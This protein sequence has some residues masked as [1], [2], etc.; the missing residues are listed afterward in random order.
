MKII[1]QIIIISGLFLTGAKLDARLF[2]IGSNPSLSKIAFP[3]DIL[4]IK[5]SSIS[6]TLGYQFLPYWGDVDNAVNKPNS[7]YAS[8][9]EEI[10]FPVELED[11]H[12]STFKKSGRV[13]MF[14]HSI[15]YNR[16]WTNR[17]S[18]MFTL[19]YKH[20]DMKSDASGTLPATDNEPDL[21]Y[22]GFDYKSLRKSWLFYFESIL[23]YKAG[24]VPLG[25]KLG[26]GYE[27]DN[28][29]VSKFKSIAHGRYMESKRLLWGWSTVGC[30]HIFG[31]R[32]LRGDA[33]FKNS[34]TAGPT[35]QLD[36]QAG[37][38]FKRAKVGARYR[39]R[40]GKK[41]NYKWFPLFDYGDEALPE[42]QY[43]ENFMGDYVKHKWS[44]ESYEH[45]GRIYVN[46]LLKKAKMGNINL[47]VF[48][49]V[50]HFESKNVISEDSDFTN[51]S[52]EGFVN[53]VGE[54]NP[55]VNIFL[56]R[57]VVIDA[58]MLCEF[59]WTGFKNMQDRWA[60]SIGARKETYS[61][62]YVHIGDEPSWESFSHATEYFFDLGFEINIQ[63]PL[64]KNKDHLLAVTLVFFN[65]NKFTFIDKRYGVNE[66]IFY[67]I[68]F[69]SNAQRKIEKEE[70][71]LNTSITLFYKYKHF[72]LSFTYIE[73][74]IYS[75]KQKE[76]IVGPM[77]CRLYT[78]EK[79]M[80]TSIF[81][82]GNISPNPTM[83]GS[84]MLMISA[85]YQF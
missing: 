26:F 32:H 16:I 20:M 84:E 9:S 22:V 36:I 33:W 78:R 14:R 64:F 15:K 31:Y 55:N 3:Q 65:N 30:N 44:N 23:S 51:S 21:E 59:S 35:Y 56:G 45:I 58:G 29:P 83:T 79:R 24:T 82:S 48:F 61:N 71:W 12:M 70:I 25:L 63:A 62:S 66:E 5:R 73:P 67:D 17:L 60:G 77:H 75:L 2:F 53:L 43:V 50:D 57:G 4:L 80:Q 47:L 27:E 18:T 11:V 6:Y 39:L 46:A 81:E 69:V 40:I 7:S 13:K 52:K 1:I 38:T 74:I 37:A 42:E 68:K 10:T 76:Y 41:D 19:T 49:A 28:K 8:I 72:F 54:L 85:G 34:Y